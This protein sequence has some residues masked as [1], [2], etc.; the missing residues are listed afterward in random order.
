MDIFY[1]NDHVESVFKKERM[2]IPFEIEL[3]DFLMRSVD[4]FLI[5][6]GSP[7]YY[8]KARRQFSL[9]KYGLVKILPEDLFELYNLVMDNKSYD[10]FKQVYKSQ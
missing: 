2:F 3:N 9:I 8:K 4:W 1:T 7:E 6:S 5:S 10:K